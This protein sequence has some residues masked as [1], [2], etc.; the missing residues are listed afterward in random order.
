MFSYRGGLGSLRF[1]GATLPARKIICTNIFP[2][3]NGSAAMILRLSPKGRHAGS[4]FSPEP[5][6]AR[7]PVMHKQRFT[8]GSGAIAR[9]GWCDDWRVDIPAHLNLYLLIG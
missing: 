7:A 8:A 6:S 1:T 5:S 9:H 3:N 2:L 4:S